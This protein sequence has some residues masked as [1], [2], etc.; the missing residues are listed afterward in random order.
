M[1]NGSNTFP[2]RGR[3]LC[4]LALAIVL[5]MASDARAHLVSTELGPFYDGAVHALMSPED[6][7]TIVGL[8]ILAGFA[9][10]RAG[11]LLLVT[12]ILTWFVGVLAGFALAPARWEVPVVTASVILLLGVTGS[13]K[14]R[15]PA[16]ILLWAAG[17]VGLGRG[18]MNGSAVRA[19]GGQ[20]LSVVGVASGVFVLGAL[21]TGTSA[22]LQ[23]KR[24]AVLLRVTA[25]WVAAI[26]LLMLGWQL[27]G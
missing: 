24:A 8:A 9:G 2:S 3:A 19:D 7:L 5:L 6:L 11:R 23:D 12:L 15:V 20:W 18:L 26:G 16:D 22:W 21:L 25:S 1:D 10:L 14:A 4:K 27:R 17:I 13:F